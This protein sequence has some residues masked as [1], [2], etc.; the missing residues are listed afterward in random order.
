MSD[1]VKAIFQRSVDALNELSG[2]IRGDVRADRLSRALYSTDASIY[3]MTPAGVVLPRSVEDVCETLRAGARHGAPITARGAGTGLAGG[4]VNVGIQLDCSRYLN[5]IVAMD[6]ARRMAIVEPGVVLDELNAALAPMGLHVAPDVATSSRATLGGMIANNSCGAHSVLVGRTVDHVLALEAVLSDGSVARWGEAAALA[7]LERTRGPIPPSRLADDAE[8]SLSGIANEFASEIAAR[9]PKVMRRNGGYALDRLRTDGERVN[10]ETI[11]CGSEGTLAVVTAAVLKLTPLPACRGLVVAHFSDLL[12]SLAATPVCLEHG[13]AA[14]ELID[15]LILDAARESRHGAARDRLIEG[16]P[17]GIL[18]IELYDE[19]VERLNE[20]LQGVAGDL[21]R[22]GMGYAWP[23]VIDAAHQAGVW[24]LRKAGLGLLMS[25]PGERQPYD[26]VDDCA[27][28]P[29]RLRDFIARFMV[30]LREEGVEECSYYAHASVGCLHVKPV[31]NLRRLSDVRRMVRVADR[32]SALTLE[33][34]GAFTGEHGDGL[35]R[36]CW[37]ERMFGPAL[38]GAFARVKA[39]FDPGN[40]L[41]PGKIVS[42]LGMA[43][44][45]RWRPVEDE[46]SG[47]GADG[48]AR[49]HVAHRPVELTVLDF[50]AH[51]GMAGLAEMCSGVGQCRSRLVGTMCPS[52]MAT[53]DERDTTRGR[54]NALRLALGDHGLLHGLDDPAL[55][56][57]MDLCLSCKACKTECP[58]GVDMAKLKAEWLRRRNEH[59]GVPWRSRAVAAMPSLSKWM[60]VAP[61]FANAV[62][63]SRLTRA[64]M[65]RFIG[66]DRRI[67]PPRLAKQTFRAWWRRR[68]GRGGPWRGESDARVADGGEVVYFVD[69]WTNY[70]APQVGVAAV[71]VLEALGCRVRVVDNVCCG[72]PAISKGL[73]HEASQLAERNIALLAP[74]AELGVPIVGTEPSCILTFG[75]EAP[76]LLRSSAARQVARHA[77]MIESFLS[78]RSDALRRLAPAERPR[79]LYHAHCHQ[80][81]MP[82]STAAMAALG[83]VCDA[84]EIPSGCCGMAGS[85]GHEVEHYDVARAIGEQRLFP[86]VRGSDGARVAVSGFSCR[87][88]IAH[89]TDRRPVHL[90]E[91]IAE[92]IADQPPCDIVARK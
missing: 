42:P 10:V 80:K 73:L 64:A 35:V 59:V 16:D 5:R 50:S 81:A 77:M 83:A 40:I 11:L 58:T 41:N 69:T 61:G 6:A 74:F 51:G 19:S 71:R 34:G 15:K 28:D 63:Q 57:V 14:V 23:V 3:Q 78:R 87:E 84:A 62:M 1:A 52:Y 72:R 38:V 17:R 7:E 70:Y 4:A 88:Q 54:A 24:N 20:R 31:L 68:A 43:D 8:R 53:G 49:G 30:V 37:L 39:A 46:A 85:F 36:S 90:I 67:A 18:V 86:A 25:R 45:L 9:Y 44:N 55:D 82:G 65:E 22:R 79:I 33:F 32:I 89:H 76:Q 91:I 56:E 48:P 27:V 26:F 47:E 2:R 66:F 13:P 29:A 12:D 92:Q 75:D 21:R 60:S